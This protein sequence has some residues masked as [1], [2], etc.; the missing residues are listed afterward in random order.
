MNCLVN[1][2]DVLIENR[3]RNTR[4]N[5]IFSTEI[6]QK[7]FQNPRVLVFTSAFHC[8]RSKASFEK[9]GLQ[10]DVFPVDFKYNDPGFNWEKALIPSDNAWQLWGLLIHE[11]TGFVIYKIM[12]YA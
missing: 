1:P 9:A 8:R 2:E 6:I 3:A 12:G 11:I 4:E 5:A 10:V 7:Q